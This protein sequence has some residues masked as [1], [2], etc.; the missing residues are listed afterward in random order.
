MTLPFHP[1]ADL[2]P[3]IEGAAFDELVADI[4][5]NGLLEKIVLLD[6]QILD[7]RN[8]YRAA[9]ASGRIKREESPYGF[10]D[11]VTAWW[12]RGFHER[13]DGDP[14]KWVLSKN[15]HRRHLT[16]GQLAAIGA[17]MG[18]LPVGR[19]SEWNQGGA[20]GGQTLL[21]RRDLV[22]DAGAGGLEARDLA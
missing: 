20:L 19:P 4:K 15:L 13:I 1:Y 6:G 21:D 22:A 11:V 7:G 10:S 5:A 18:K 12:A 16:P 9:I 17:D 2:F 14:L 8:R 3:L